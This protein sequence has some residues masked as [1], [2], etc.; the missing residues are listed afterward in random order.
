MV[1]TGARVGEACGL[2]WDQVD[3]DAKLVRIVRRVFWDHKTKMPLLDDCAKTQESVRL[4]LLSQE[5]QKILE[6]LRDESIGE[7]PVFKSSKGELLK[8]NAIQSAFNAGF[9]ALN[10]PW[11][12]TRRLS[13]SFDEER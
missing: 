9:V 4:M 11:R 10:L 12:S 5:L 6:Q 1:L 7:G 13:E 3:F 2:M 8:Y